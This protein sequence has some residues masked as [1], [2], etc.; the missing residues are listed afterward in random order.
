MSM[1]FAVLLVCRMPVSMRT[2]PVVVLDE[3]ATQRQRDAIAIVGAERGGAPE[4]LGDDAEHGAAVEVLAP[5]F[6]GRGSGRPPTFKGCVSQRA[7]AAPFPLCQLQHLCQTLR[8][9]PTAVRPL[10]R[11]RP[12]ISIPK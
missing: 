5:G 10:A 12:S 1:N 9:P 6:E 2:R 4:R 8:G 7:F 11:C 3:Q